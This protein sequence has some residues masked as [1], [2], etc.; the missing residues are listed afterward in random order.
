MAMIPFTGRTMPGATLAS[1]REEM[2]DLLGRFWSATA[3]PFGLAEWSPPLDISETD[4]AVMVDVEV[5]GLDPA[6]MDISVTGD[7]LTI[8]G[9]KRDQGA[10][11]GRNYHRAER[12]YGAFTRSLTLPAPVEADQVEA[13]ARFGVLS[14]RLPKKAAARARRV[15]IKSD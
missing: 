3:E 13:K 15:Q 5:P 9:E 12:R 6:A 2:N 11:P 8:R 14:I 10:V 1:L 7:V 4:D